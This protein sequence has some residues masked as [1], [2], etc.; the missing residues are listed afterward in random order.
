MKKKKRCLTK[1]NFLLV[2][3]D[4]Y[5]KNENARSLRE[6]CVSKREGKESERKWEWG[7][8]RR[9]GR[10]ECIEMMVK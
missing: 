8:E 6:G 1:Y 4:S 5:N 3:I 7:S 10:G 9:W 2:A